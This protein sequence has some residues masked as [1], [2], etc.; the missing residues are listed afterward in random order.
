MTSSAPSAIPSTPGEF[1]CI[2]LINSAFTQYLGTEPGFDRLPL[3]QWQAWFLQRYRLEVGTQHPVPVEELAA[4]REQLCAILQKWAVT[5]S[6]TAHDAEAL[7][8]WVSRPPLRQRVAVISGRAGLTLEP[9]ARDWN[10]AMGRIAASVLEMA[11]GNAPMRLKACGNPAC[12][13]MFYDQTLNRSRK[14]CSASHCGNVM[15]VRRFR[16]QQ[17]RR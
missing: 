17:A 9:I 2:D 15:R 7:D 6:L 11:A 12:R 5:G 10:W 3:R 8:R 1:A 13:R 16:A 4:L 14:F